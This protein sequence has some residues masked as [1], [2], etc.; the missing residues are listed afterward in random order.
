MFDGVVL[1]FYLDDFR[2]LK[3]VKFY[4]ENYGF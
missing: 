1:L 2:V 3:E 4:M